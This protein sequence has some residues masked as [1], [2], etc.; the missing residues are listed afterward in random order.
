MSRAE[1]ITQQLGMPHGTAANKLRKNVLFHLLSRLNENVCFKCE[2][3]IETVDELSI[4][5]VKPWEGC[6][7]DLFWD[8]SN[9][10]FSHISCNLPHAYRGGTPKRIIAPDGMSW[11]SGHKKFLPVEAFYK[12]KARWTGLQVNCKECHDSNRGR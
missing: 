2:G 11:C 6:S 8:M 9:I 7:A 5:H 4:E 3:A 10:A 12:T 1:R